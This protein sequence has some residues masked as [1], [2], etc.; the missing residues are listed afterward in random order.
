MNPHFDNPICCEICGSPVYK[1][2]YRNIDNEGLYC[3][4]DWIVCNT[5]LPT[6]M[7]GDGMLRDCLKHAIV[8]IHRVLKLK[9][10]QLRGVRYMT[11]KELWS[12]RRHKT[13]VEGLRN[14]YN[15]GMASSNAVIVLRPGISQN[16]AL[17]TMAHEIAHIWQFEYWPCFALMEKWQVEGFAEWVDRKSVV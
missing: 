8:G 17:V 3:E 12:I 11:R 16:L 2:F 7:L 14:S 1:G 5:C 13:I 10:N 9:I 6:A 15:L 4:G